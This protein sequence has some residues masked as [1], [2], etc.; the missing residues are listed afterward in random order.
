[1][2]V[3]SFSPHRRYEV[4]REKIVLIKIRFGRKKPPGLVAIAFWFR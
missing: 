3:M 1:M 2:H 4:I